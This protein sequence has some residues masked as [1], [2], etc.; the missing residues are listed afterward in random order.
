MRILLIHNQYLQRGGEDT[1]F[2]IEK[3]LLE[4]NGDVVD[5]I[6][7]DNA[8]IKSWWSR[9]IYLIR[10]IY[11]RKAYRIVEEKIKTFRPDV[12]HLHNFFYVGSPAIFFAAKKHKVPI[13]QTLHNYR[14]ICPSVY[15]YHDGDVYEESVDKIFP[16]KAIFKRV[17]NNSLLQTA[18]I[19]T[20]TAVHKWL[21]TFRNKVDGFIV[22]TPFAKQIFAKSSLNVA[23][24]KFFIKPNFTEDFGV[25]DLPREDFFL[26]IGRLSEEKGIETLM[27]A[28]EVYDFSLK[29]LGDGPLRDLVE[30]YAKDNPRIDYVGRKNKPEVID[31]LKKAKA[32]LFPSTWYEGMPMVILEALSTGT[33]V[34]C[35]D[36][37]NPA[38]MVEAGVSGL[39][40][41]PKNPQKLAEVIELLDKDEDLFQTLSQG[42]RSIYE[43]KYS[44]SM[45]YNRLKEIYEKVGMGFS[46]NSARKLNINSDSNLKISSPE[47]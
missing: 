39:R 17:C 29:I 38:F 14:L 19:V 40:F 5:T 10:S 33:P 8:I 44:P 4:E 41:E 28:T 7:F 43:E 25:S 45:N 1:V 24:E 9:I 27:K 13:V 3:N 31:T 22:F 16:I 2:E 23:P 34:I 18:S 12:I 30:T 6:L 35:S 32:L 47:I 42:A 15:L 21:G 46:V 37:G 26:F 36:L 20:I 11:N